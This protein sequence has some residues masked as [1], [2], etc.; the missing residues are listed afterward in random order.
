MRSTVHYWCSLVLALG[1]LLPAAEA[2]LVNYEETWQEFLKNPKTSAISKLTE[3]GKEQEANYLKYSLMYANS[4]FCADDLRQSESMLKAMNQRWT[5]F[6][7][8]TAVPQED[9][10]GGILLG[11]KSVCEKGTLCKYFYV[12]AMNYYCEGDLTKSRG[13]FQNR[14]QKL[15]DKTSFEP[16]QVRGMEERV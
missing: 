9:L 12:T 5:D 14:V 10:E 4:Y 16:S 15:V 2:Q 3:P 11:A 7:G 6:I 1:F 13:H 8:G